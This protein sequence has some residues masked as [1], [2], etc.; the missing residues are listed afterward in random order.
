[1]DGSLISVII[2]IYN[3]EQYLDDCVTSV[4]NQSH[5]NLE[6]IL[7]DDG[8]PDNCPK[9]C[10]DWVKR[11][12]RIKVVHKKNGGLSSARNAGL[13]VA[14]GDYIG[15]V[16]SDDYI[17]P[18]MYSDLL[19]SLECDSGNIAVA[20]GRILEDRNGVI[21]PYKKEWAI[22]KNRIITYNDFA[23]LTILTKIGFTV[24]SKLYKTYILHEV[25][26]REGRN[27]EDTLFMFDL[28]KVLEK[29]GLGMVDVAKDVY[30]YRLRDNSIC[31]KPKVP[32]EIDVVKNFTEIANYYI[33]KKDRE[34][35]AFL[36]KR[37]SVLTQL[38]AKLMSNKDWEDQFFDECYGEF[39][40]IQIKTMLPSKTNLKIFVDFLIMRYMLPLA[41][42]YMHKK[43]KI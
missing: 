27:N 12:N 17:A 38:V 16:D 8:S 41:K 14:T 33:Q 18:N 39:K 24:W 5:K 28:S 3:V 2:P 22:S 35:M 30:Y 7:V 23:E 32:L 10:D 37:N 43:Y 26:F 40:K 4:V 11:D 34:Y 29:K 25:R 6:I 20:N 15:F 42:F 9:K 21:K 13:D 1:M 19:D 31:R 36:S